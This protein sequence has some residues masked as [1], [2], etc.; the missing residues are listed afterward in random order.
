[1]RRK[2]R[3]AL[4]LSVPAAVLIPVLLFSALGYGY[5]CSQTDWLDGP[6][7]MGP[8]ND[9]GSEFYCDTEANWDAEPGA[10]M[11]EYSPTA[12]V[13][14]MGSPL[15]ACTGDFDGDGHTDA[16]SA[17]WWHDR[18]DYHLN[19]DGAG[20]LWDSGIVVEDFDYAIAVTAGDMNEDGRDDIVASAY[21]DDVLSL[22]LSPETPGGQWDRLDMDTIVGVTHLDASDING[23]GH[24]DVIGSS[25]N[26]NDLSWWENSGTGTQWTRHMV[27]G[28]VESPRWA[29]ARDMDDDGD[30]DILSVSYGY[31]YIAWWENLN[32]SGET[33]TAHIIDSFYQFPSSVDGADV[34]QDGDMDVVATSYVHGLVTLWENVDGTGTSWEE[35]QIGSA[36]GAGAATGCDIDLDGD[37]DVSVCSYLQD[38]LIWLENLDGTGTQWAHHPCADYID[39]EMLSICDINDDGTPDFLSCSNE[40]NSVVWWDHISDRYPEISRLES[41]IFHVTGCTFP[42]DWG[43]LSWSG[44]EPAGTSLAFLVRSSDHPDSILLSTA[45]SDTITTSGTDLTGILGPDDYYFQYKAL[46][47]SNTL[48]T[49]VLED[50]TVTWTSMATEGQG[51][52]SLPTPGLYPASNPS[53]GSVTVSFVP[54]A[55]AGAEITLFD[56]AGRVLRTRSYGR[57][58]CG[59]FTFDN[60][61]AGIYCT[62]MHSGP[63]YYRRLLTVLP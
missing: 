42:V 43:T 36:E 8:V 38:E 5:E 9:F 13:I 62:V 48:E 53:R 26:Y 2:M 27:S 31:S 11:C 44:S 20:T 46:L 19:S 52:A 59:S 29:Q 63:E 58:V 37:I 40:E 18:I 6:G 7:V 17:H 56:L 60:L 16:A 39:P 55:G 12:Q 32:G 51:S 45:W 1:M 57:D 28:S 24:M 15:D 3:R 14:G 25:V 4:S 23:D 50:V 10:L 21:Y 61:P 49:P 35:S 34:D 47:C 33:W 54:R 22:F 41:S 30:L